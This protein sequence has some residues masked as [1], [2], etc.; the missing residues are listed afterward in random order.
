MKISLVVTTKNEEGNIGTLLTSLIN[1]EAPL[2]IVVVDSSSTDRTLE[3]VESFK[4]RFDELSVYEYESMPGGGKNYGVEKAKGEFVAFIDADCTASPLWLKS[5]RNSAS[6]HEIVVG[7]TINVST[8]KFDTDTTGKIHFYWKGEEVT[9][10]G[11][12]ILYRKN[13][14]QDLD[15][16]DEELVSAEDIDLNIRAV[17]RGF[18]LFYDEDAVLY[19]RMRSDISSLAKQ[20]FWRGHGRGQIME[21]HGDKCEVKRDS[22]SRWAWL[23]W[24]LEFIGFLKFKIE[25]K[26]Q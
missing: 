24:I 23:K 16:F 26:R 15:G 17:E 11:C 9:W 19:H 13:V 20:M 5:L 25:G 18:T 21:K 10:P 4:E 14:F 2:E 8:S 12:N 6:S 1:Q 22:L 7:N 3:I